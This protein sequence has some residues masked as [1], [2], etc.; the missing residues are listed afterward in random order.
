MALL[1]QKV[2]LPLLMPEMHAGHGLL[3]NDAI[4]VHNMAVEIAAR[5]HASGWSEWRMFPQGAAGN[6]GVLSAIYAL[7]GPDPVWFIPLNA[8]AHAIGA[9]MLYRMGPLLWRGNAGQLGGL[10]AGIAFLVFP[11]ALQWYGQNLKDAFAIAG[12]LLVLDA[13]LDLHSRPK[14][15]MRATALLALRVAMGAIL[16]GVV[17]P[18]HLVVLLIAILAS[19]AVALMS[20]LVKRNGLTMHSVAAQLL[21][22]LS[23]MIIAFIFSKTV[24]ITDIHVADSFEINSSTPQQNSRTWQWNATADL[25]EAID[26][27]L[28]R[29]S[30]LRAHFVAYGRSVGAGSE[31]DGERLPDNALGA[32]AYMP[33]ALFVGIFA[34]FPDNW[35]ERVTAT[36]LV[37]AMETAVW[38]LLALGILVTLWRMPSRPLLAGMVFCVC[39]IAILAYMHPNVGTLYRQRFGLWHFF[40]L[41]GATGWVSLLLSYIEQR[42]SVGGLVDNQRNINTGYSNRAI[43]TS[44][45]I[46]RLA[47]SSAIVIMITLI[48]Y[49]GFF[50]RDLL[51]LKQ[52]GMGDELDAFFTAMMIPMFF[53]TWLSMPLADAMTGPFISSGLTGQ[54]QRERLIRNL[55]GFAILLLGTVTVLVIIAAP[56]FAGWVLGDTGLEKLASTTSIVRWFAPVILLSV[57]LIVG[58]AALNALG[59]QRNAAF[60]QLFAPTITIAALVLASPYNAVAATIGGMLFGT[61]LNIVWVLLCLRPCGLHLTPVIPTA[62]ALGPVTAQYRRLLLAA[63]LPAILVP[64]NYSFAVGVTSGTVSAWA[65][66]SKLVVLFSGLASV[67][68]TAVVLPHLVH[69]LAHGT[70]REMREDANLLLVLGT[71]VG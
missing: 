16:L 5:I 26:K 59:Q 66:A 50:V 12:I 19:F 34:P 14:V 55:L 21:L 71:W 20:G 63:L 39:W 32:M 65:F 31:I 27:R 22:V 29:A 4:G 47:A 9:L 43:G 61:L 56:Y 52:L 2:I 53:V 49:L 36:R 41:C 60:G 17:R 23:V 58:N 68:A 70:R 30:Q 35:G 33:R 54:G 64:L 18:P 69:L 67:G 57:W 28:Q 7:L 6:V 1:F 48:S 25:P 37:G 24:T 8:A 44:S 10:V 62:A 46:D 40:L 15:S 3:L 42:Q 51:M 38:Y 45:G 13:W 11:S